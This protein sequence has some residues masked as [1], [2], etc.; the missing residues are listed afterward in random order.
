MTQTKTYNLNNRVQ[1]L[2]LEKWGA[3]ARPVGY[4][5]LFY[6]G[7]GDWTIKVQIVDGA[8]TWFRGH[9]K[10]GHQPEFE[11]LVLTAPKPEPEMK[12]AQ[13]VWEFARERKCAG[14]FT[15]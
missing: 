14:Y 15:C 12:S 1:W 11:W 13:E 7:T 4:A 3:P 6:E 8:A 9:L 10:P 2:Q 5:E